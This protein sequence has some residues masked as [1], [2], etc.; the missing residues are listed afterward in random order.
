MEFANAGVGGQP[1]NNRVL[2][3]ATTDNKYSHATGAYPV[4]A[5]SPRTRSSVGRSGD[6]RKPRAA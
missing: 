1:P 6:P 5:D 4:P 3:P 2:P